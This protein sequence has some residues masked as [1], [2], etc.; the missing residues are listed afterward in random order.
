[1][2][3]EFP[4]TNGKKFIIKLPC[5]IEQLT[6]KDKGK[7]GKWANNV[8]TAISNKAKLEARAMI[9]FHLSEA[10]RIK[11]EWGF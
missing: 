5:P 3:Y 4:L 9:D 8:I 11:K 7:F 2:T 1:M 6:K 10:E